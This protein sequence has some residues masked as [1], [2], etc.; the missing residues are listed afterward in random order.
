MT[1]TEVIHFLG[2]IKAYYQN[3]C[4]DS[5]VVDEW[6]D[7]L[8]NYNI[9]DVYRKLDEHLQG[10]YRNEIPKLHYITRYLS[11][12]KERREYNTADKYVRCVN[13]NKLVKL[14]EFDKHVDR[15]NSVDYLCRM[16]QKHFNKRLDAQ[17]LM[18]VEEERFEKY[19][20]DFCDR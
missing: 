12:E 15:C 3:F 6:Y 9:D 1:K 17:K 7:R 20:W 4:K 19:Y 14:I 18:E 2:K 5:Y 13:C 11:V 16:S 10:E 8:K